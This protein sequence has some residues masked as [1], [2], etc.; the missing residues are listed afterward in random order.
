[1]IKL[2]IFDCDGILTEYPLETWLRKSKNF[3]RRYGIDFK[4]QDLLWNNTKKLVIIGNISLEKSQDMIFKKLGL[5]ETLIRKW[6]RMDVMIVKTITKIKPLVRSTLKKLNKKYKMAV[7]SDSVHNRMIKSAMLKNKKIDKF[8]DAVFCSC[9]IGYQKP[10]KEA[11]F[12]VLNYFKIKPEEAIFIGHSKDE[13]EG[14]RKY[15]MRTIAIDWDKETK[16][17]F[18]V[19]K[20]S[21]IPKIL[22]K[23]K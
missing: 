12:T 6:R 20:F 10:E 9:D 19:K 7:L 13:I 4:H 21:E 15:K 16:S 8:F 17:D 5:N 14:A 11:Y 2:L 18:Y 23:I 1:M 22:E 3:L